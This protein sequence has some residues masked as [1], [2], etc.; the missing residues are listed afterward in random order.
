M[1]IFGRAAELRRPHLML[2]DVGGDNAL[3]S[4][5]LVQTIEYVLRTQAAFFGIFQRIL[6]APAGDIFQPLGGVD[7]ADQRNE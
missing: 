6:F 1:T 7:F 4:A 2:A 3:T 5:E